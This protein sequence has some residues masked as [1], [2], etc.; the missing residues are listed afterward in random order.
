VVTHEALGTLHA[1]NNRVVIATIHH[2][3]CSLS[4]SYFVNPAWLN[5]SFAMN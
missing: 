4:F 5:K 1:A 3:V 2:G